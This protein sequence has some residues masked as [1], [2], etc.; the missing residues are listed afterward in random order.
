[1]PVH[2]APATALVLVTAAVFT[3]MLVY[4]VLMPI[5]P[6]YAA[7][8]GASQATIGVLF[9]CYALALLAATPVF[10]VLSD[11]VGRRRPMLWGMF[12]LAASTLI[13][14]FSDRLAELVLARLL[15]GISAAA[16]WTAG[17]ALL[18]DV[19]PPERRGRAMGT[20]MGGTVV[21]TLVG[22][23][24]GGLLFDWGGYALPFLAT[25]AGAALEGFTLSVLL[26]EP[27]P[28]QAPGQPGLIGLLRDRTILL[29]AGAI[30]VQAGAL[31]LL[32]PTLPLYLQQ[33]FA[34]SPGVI[35]LLFGVFTLAYGIGTPLSGTLSDRWRRRP[36]MA[37]GLLALAL[38]LP[39][40]ALP[41]SL[42]AQ[43][44]VLAL[45]GLASGLILA[46]ALP[47]LA[48][49]VDRLGGGAYAS[50]YAILNIAYAVG[51]IAGPIAGG[52]S[53]DAFGFAATLAAVA[54]LLLLYVPLLL[55]AGRR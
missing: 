14:A 18:A 4:G 47:A 7:T 30:A 29:I 48:D 46:P 36:V 55:A 27:P 31:T 9:A 17:L 25:A 22:P 26:A 52:L 16:T 32:E 51:M 53:A 41:A 1:M 2:A 24:F 35:G 44:A 11:R 33:R 43:A 50:V 19:F 34:A 23:P 54:L 42:P 38:V 12:G 15:Q 13:F 6:I 39:L 3:D 49:E 5:L 20:A 21:G 37:L 45:A 28:R 10:G 8:L 40:L